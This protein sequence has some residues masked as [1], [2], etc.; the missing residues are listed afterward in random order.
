MSRW[1]GWRK[2][3]RAI[4]RKDAVEREMD[5]E[6]AF[7]L[8]MEVRKNLSL[9]MSPR[10]VLAAATSNF[11]KIFPNWGAVGEVRKNQRADLLVLSEDPREEVSNLRSIETVILAGEVLELSALLPAQQH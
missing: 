2:R 6:M 10:E 3:I 9:G 8:E 11:S 1:K 4:L 7:H 5:E